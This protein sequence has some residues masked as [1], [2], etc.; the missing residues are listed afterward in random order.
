MA[1]SAIVHAR[2]VTVSLQIAITIRMGAPRRAS[3][4]AL[5]NASARDSPRGPN[6]RVGPIG[7]TSRAGSA[8][9]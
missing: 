7:G 5:P 8:G 6:H 9:T 2:S 3:A 1:R 4:P